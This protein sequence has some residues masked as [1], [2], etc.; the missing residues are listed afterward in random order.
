M[1]PEKHREQE[2][3]QKEDREKERPKLVPKDR[4]FFDHHEQRH[5][6]SKKQTD[7]TIVQ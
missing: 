6:K 1:I 5:K 7:I 2:A 4:E 3:K